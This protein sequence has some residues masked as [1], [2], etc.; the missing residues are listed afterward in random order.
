[1]TEK[2]IYFKVNKNLRGLMSRWRIMTCVIL[3]WSS[4]RNCVHFCKQPFVRFKAMILFSFVFM[5]TNSESNHF[6]KIS[7]GP[8]SSL[9]LISLAR[10]RVSLHWYSTVRSMSMSLEQQFLHRGQACRCLLKCP[11]SSPAIPAH[12]GLLNFRDLSEVGEREGM[13][14]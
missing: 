1:M 14:S 8:S 9:V 4:T 5:Y 6:L 11:K 10:R 3:S 7:K 2:T 13:I 12:R